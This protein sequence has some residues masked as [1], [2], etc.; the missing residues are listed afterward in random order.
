MRSTRH[1]TIRTTVTAA[2]ALTFVLSSS[3]VATAAASD[4]LEIH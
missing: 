2:A 1:R 4:R 3:L